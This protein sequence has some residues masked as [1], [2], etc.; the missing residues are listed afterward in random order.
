MTS[1]LHSRVHPPE[2]EIHSPKTACGCP[3]GWV[4]RKKDHMRNPLTLWNA[5]N[6]LLYFTVVCSVF[7]WGIRQQL[8]GGEGGGRGQQEGGGSTCVVLQSPNTGLRHRSSN[9]WS[10]ATAVQKLLANWQVFVF[11]WCANGSSFITTQI[12][13]GLFIT[14]QI[15]PGVVYNNSEYIRVV[16]NNSD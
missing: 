3:C 7:S 4:V 12:I 2:I 6:C 5:V 8:L 10:F 14:T 16:C 1:A 13:L 9:L 11:C 15:T